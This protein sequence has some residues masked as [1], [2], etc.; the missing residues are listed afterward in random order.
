METQEQPQQ[1]KYLKA[2]GK[3]GII[4]K[5][6]QKAT[7]RGIIQMKNTNRPG[8]KIDEIAKEY[9]FNKMLM[10]SQP[11]GSRE[12]YKSILSRIKKRAK[13]QIIK[14]L[15]ISDDH[16]ELFGFKNSDFSKEIIFRR[17]MIDFII[18]ASEKDKFYI[19]AMREHA[20][21]GHAVDF[22][23]ANDLRR[24]YNTLIDM[25]RNSMENEPSELK[26]RRYEEILQI[27]DL[28][29]EELNLRNKEKAQRPNLCYF[30][31]Y[32]EKET[33]LNPG[34]ADNNKEAI[35]DGERFKEKVYRLSK[36]NLM[37]LIRIYRQAN[38]IFF[39]NDII[40]ERNTR[41]MEGNRKRYKAKRIFTPEETKG[42]IKLYKADGLNNKQVAEIIGCGLRTVERYSKQYS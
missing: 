38:N 25:D 13:A 21:G 23:F 24:K 6:E 3:T 12:K 11:D 1:S 5:L 2:E 36:T 26:N 33:N 18:S 27:F 34:S 39:H 16:M 19:D 40:N 22:S 37:E 20:K 8:R 7:M 10:N 41:K 28:I 30:M 9:R 14:D 29:Y 15:I 32:D 4:T 17:F 35:E 31:L 42:F